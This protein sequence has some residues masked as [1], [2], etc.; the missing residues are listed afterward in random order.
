MHDMPYEQLAPWGPQSQRQLGGAR[1]WDVRVMS[2]EHP[3]RM[4]ERRVSK[5]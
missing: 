4:G 5:I 3:N 2:D 1:S